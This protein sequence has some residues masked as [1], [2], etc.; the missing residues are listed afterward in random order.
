M[1]NRDSPT[2]AEWSIVSHSEN[3]TESLAARLA[4]ALE[5]GT[6]VALVGNLGAGKTRL[7]R[8]VA[9]ALGVDC[10]AVASPT[11][12]LVHEYA[13]RLPIFHFDVYRLREAADFLELG[14]D[15]YLNS[16]GVCFV[17]WA[18]RVEAFLP[19]DHLRIEIVATGETTR[20]FRFLS[21][22][23]KAGDVVRKLQSVR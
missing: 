5:P 7:V 15:E 16:G 9:E 23:A 1:I 19:P 12:V 13:G 11:F 18:D 6:V 2:K 20:E 22:G 3:E 14:A 21:T 4:D 10:R 8:A 17:E